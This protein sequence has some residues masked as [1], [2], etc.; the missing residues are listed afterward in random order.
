MTEIELESAMIGLFPRH[1]DEERS[2]HLS[3]VTGPN[4]V[5][6]R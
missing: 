6:T 2:A 1:P 4:P 3:E 5:T